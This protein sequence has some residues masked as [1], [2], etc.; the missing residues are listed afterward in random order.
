M[1]VNI[2]KFNND[3][4]ELKMMA[5]HIR[6]LV[7]VQEQNVSEEIEYDEFESICNHYLLFFHSKPAATCRWRITE[8]GVKL[9][10]FAV[11]K[12]FRGKGVGFKLLLFVMDEV[13]QLGKTV[14][15]HAQE[16]VIP[17]YESAGFKAHGE[18]FIEADIR[19]FIMKYEK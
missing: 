11:L 10:R 9:E 15:M 14:Y 2:V 13:L 18:V 4:H 19:H 12:E 3:E 6:R 7:F 16:A 17:F 8:K 1:E 5:D